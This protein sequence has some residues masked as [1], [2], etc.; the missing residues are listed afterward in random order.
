MTN[1]CLLKKIKLV[2]FQINPEKSEVTP[3]IN[4]KEIADEVASCQEKSKLKSSTVLLLLLLIFSLVTTG[5]FVYQNYQLKQAPPQVGISVTPTPA[6]TAKL[7]PEST[8]QITSF[9]N[10]EQVEWRTARLSQVSFDYPNGWHVASYHPTQANDPI[11][12]WISPEP[13]D[14][15]PGSPPIQGVILIRAYNGYSNPEEILEQEIDK[16]KAELENIKEEGLTV[17]NT[18]VYKISGTVKGLYLEGSRIVNYHGMFS[19]PNGNNLNKEVVIA[20]LNYFGEDQDKLQKYESVLD[21][22]VLSIKKPF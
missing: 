9:T 1:G 11:R 12:I 6:P 21:R 7:S 20:G 2:N 10:L 14:G 13:I 4:K 17:Y 18:T 5:F 15:A 16:T 3:K 8:Q 22:I 19:N